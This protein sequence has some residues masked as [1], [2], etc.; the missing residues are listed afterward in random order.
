MSLTQ[1]LNTA[2]KQVTEGSSG[3]S[4]TVPLAL[5]K[6]A[7]ETHSKFNSLV[8]SSFQVLEK[9]D[10]R[11]YAKQVQKEELCKAIKKE[12]Q[13][14][15]CIDYYR[16]GSDAGASVVTEVVGAQV[17]CIDLTSDSEEEGCD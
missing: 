3:D 5:A 11:P 8:A 9:H 15:G 7:E 12:V 4:S 1:L 17:A 16:I 2:T 13:I 14:R 10:P 6:F